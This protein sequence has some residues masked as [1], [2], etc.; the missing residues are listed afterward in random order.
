ME[1]QKAHFYISITLRCKVL[2][3]KW[4]YQLFLLRGVHHLCKSIALAA[5]FRV[6]DCRYLS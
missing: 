1:V 6:Q 3:M 5:G 4:D 2:G